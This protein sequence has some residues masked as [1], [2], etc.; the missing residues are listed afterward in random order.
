MI[1]LTQ[2]RTLPKIKPELE[3]QEKLQEYMYLIEHAIIDAWRNNKSSVIVDCKNDIM[4]GHKLKKFLKSKGF[5]VALTRKYDFYL[6]TR[7]P[8]TIEI[9]FTEVE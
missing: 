9:F 3:Q 2:L 1:S 7:V 4:D 8:G 6:R 5:K